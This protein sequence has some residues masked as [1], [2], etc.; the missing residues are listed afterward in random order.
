MYYLAINLHC[1]HIGL[2]CVYYTLLLAWY[3]YYLNLPQRPALG[4]LDVLYVGGYDQFCVDVCVC[5]LSTCGHVHYLVSL[6]V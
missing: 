4:Q 1:H 3:K 6:V 5:G 2:L